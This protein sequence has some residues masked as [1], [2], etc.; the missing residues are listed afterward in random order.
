MT[1]APAPTALALALERW[2][3][4][5]GLEVHAQLRTRS[6]M[7]CGCRADY[8]GL[9]PNHNTC[10][11]C[12]GLPGA[13]PVANLE[14]IRQ[15]VLTGLALQSRIAEHSKFD[16]KNYFYPDLPKGY[17]ISQFD[18]PLCVGGWLEFDVAGAQRAARITRVHLEEDAGK[19]VHA[20]EIHHAG[21][22]FVDLNRAGVPLMEIVGEPDLRSPTE[23]RAYLVALRQLLLYL[24]VND[25][26]MEEGSLRCDANISLRP[27][28]ADTLG[29]RTEVKNLNSF[30]ILQRALEHEVVRQAAALEAGRPLAPET[31]GWSEAE[32]ATVSQRSKEEADDYRYFP[33]PDLPP[34]R[35]GRDEVE[36]LRARLPELPRARAL[37][38]R[39]MHGLSDAEA[40]ALTERPG[41]ALYFEQVVAAGAPAALAAGWQLNELAGLCQRAHRTVETSGLAPDQLARLLVLVGART[42]SGAT[43]KALLAEAI[44]TGQDPARLV[45]ERGLRQLSD[46]EQLTDQVDRAI[47]AAPRAAQD[48]QAGNDRALSALVG[49]VMAATGGRA[50]ARRVD[51][52]LRRRLPRE[53]GG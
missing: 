18:L 46:E 52:L 11:T 40:R 1:Q 20:G 23:A 30:R 50:D 12:L 29:V 39:Q 16:R 41:E 3:P 9:A 26:N 31:R 32:A 22:S 5:I 17:Q 7:F 15:T 33:D 42:V 49:A 10:P 44:E 34:I 43:A 14:A 37:R 48:F 25:G 21:F 8:V 35:L 47:A 6:K 28:G 24:G 45:D 53:G 2:E 13:L 27:R 36:A 38:L 19:L 4:V 51:A